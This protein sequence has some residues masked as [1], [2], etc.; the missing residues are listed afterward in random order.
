MKKEEAKYPTGLKLVKNKKQ[1][2]LLTK[3]KFLFIPSSPETS[4][5]GV[6]FPMFVILFNDGSLGLSEK[7]RKIQLMSYEDMNPVQKL[8]YKY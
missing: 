4:K 8:T 3:D 2:T 1:L 5:R 7:E 6:R